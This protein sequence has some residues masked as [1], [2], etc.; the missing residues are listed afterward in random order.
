MSVSRVKSSPFP[1][2]SSNPN[3]VASEKEPSSLLAHSLVVNLFIAYQVTTPGSFCSRDST[4]WHAHCARCE[5]GAQGTGRDPAP[6][7][8]LFGSF[9][10]ELLWILCT[11]RVR[12]HTWQNPAYPIMTPKGTAWWDTQEPQAQFSAGQL[13]LLSSLREIGLQ[14]LYHWGASDGEL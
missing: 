9:H 12:A 14:A 8:L 13:L 10:L 2:L 1:R 4:D 3:S 5:V 11:P 6:F 7:C